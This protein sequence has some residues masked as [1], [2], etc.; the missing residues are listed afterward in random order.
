MW[1]IE[2]RRRAAAV[3]AQRIARGWL[4]R[5]AALKQN[6]QREH[7]HACA[8]T[9]QCAWRSAAAQRLAEGHRQTRLQELR[10]QRVLGC[11]Q[12]LQRI[13]RGCQARLR[14]MPQWQRK[15]SAGDVIG[16]AWRSACARVELRRRR[17]ERRAAEW[18]SSSEMDAVDVQRICRG[19]LAKK[20][21]RALKEQVSL[22]R[23]RQRWR[24]QCVRDL[25][26][27]GRGALA[28]Q[29]TRPEHVR[30]HNAATDIERVARS[31]LTR[32]RLQRQRQ[33]QQRSDA[34]AK[35][36]P[37]VLQFAA[38]RRYRLARE[39]E[40]RKMAQVALRAAQRTEI[41]Q[42]LVLVHEAADAWAALT[43]GAAEEVARIRDR[44]VPK[45]EALPLRAPRRHLVAIQD[46]SAEGLFMK[47]WLEWMAKMGCADDLKME[48]LLTKEATARKRAYQQQKQEWAALVATEA[49]D[50]DLTRIAQ[51]EFPDAWHREQQLDRQR[52]TAR[53]HKLKRDVAQAYDP[54]WVRHCL[55]L[56]LAA[57][58]QAIAHGTDP[59]AVLPSL[60]QPKEDLQRAENKLQASW[61]QAA[62]RERA[63]FLAPA[64]ARATPRSL[65]P[66]K[67][68]ASLLPSISPPAPAERNAA[69][70]DD[71]S[72]RCKVWEP[73]VAQNAPQVSVL[74]LRHQGLTDSAL[75]P[76]LLALKGNTVVHTVLLD[77][78]R[79]TDA[80]GIELSKLLQSNAALQVLSLSGNADI[81]DLSAKHWLN[82]L[83]INTTLKD[84]QCID[85]NV[86]PQYSSQLTY[87]L[88]FAAPQTH[89]LALQN[90]VTLSRLAVS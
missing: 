39:K 8:T 63:A 34:L 50:G 36:G 3:T 70:P 32:V 74:D 49:R 20:R 30:Q 79:L 72:R 11:V 15:R 40:G 22:A 5:T 31:W 53:T 2:E 19:W 24:E 81:T 29:R 16:R 76:L 66:R 60:R 33:Q 35:I 86:S 80:T 1:C 51:R 44:A 41:E 27:V 6:T 23:T 13:T 75:L 59:D 90:Q 87:L 65:A 43:G 83:K 7:A 21:V 77:G 28:R 9:I 62:K 54:Q 4:V 71:G 45:K 37:A 88:N 17:E 89:L 73:L 48:R 68:A 56:D 52:A 61:I 69:H 78:N 55:D 18:A 14:V 84:L 85:T 38:D 58:E 10:Q 82:A 12:T 57:Q 47:G 26:R 67:G 25:Q 46:S 64:P 42:R